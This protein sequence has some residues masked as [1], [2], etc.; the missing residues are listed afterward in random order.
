MTKEEYRKAW[1]VLKQFQKE[2]QWIESFNFMYYTQWLAWKIT[3]W[4]T[5]NL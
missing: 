1:E 2:N 3:Y 4:D 5:E